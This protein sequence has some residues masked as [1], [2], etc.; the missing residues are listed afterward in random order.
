MKPSDARTHHQRVI[1][2]TSIAAA[3]AIVVVA[4]TSPKAFFYDEVEYLLGTVTLLERLGP[5][6]A[7]LL[8]YAHPA[9][10]LFG[11]MHWVFEPVTRLSPPAVRLVNPAL[12]LLL[13]LVVARLCVHAGVSRPWTSAASLACVPMTWVLAGLALTEMV[14]MLCAALGLWGF[15]AQVA[16]RADPVRRWGVI[17][18]S[19]LATG[20]AFFSRPPLL[21]VA[22]APLLYLSARP[23]PWREVTVFLASA[24]V[25]VT[26]AVLLWGGL[27]PPKVDFYSS[28]TFSVSHAALA[29][30][31]AGVVMHLLCPAWYDWSPV[32]L[33][34]VVAAAVVANALVPVLEITALGT[35]A[36]RVLAD[37]L[38]VVYPRLVGGLCLGVGAV[39]LVTTL[40]KV[41]VNR[42]DVAWLA[43][44]VTMLLIVLA[45]GKITHQFSSRYVGVAAPFM[46]VAA[47]RYRRFD[48]LEMFGAALGAVLGAASLL[49]YYW[50]G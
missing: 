14:G 38:L 45:T 36:N 25:V 26:P 2:A 11:L 41:A 44:A 43:V 21:V 28:S 49:S 7:F 27:V 35:L 6:R 23:R 19:G 39:F 50:G 24:A 47:G 22:F 1:L 13:V 10:S 9:G 46:V 4:T 12:A 40:R 3:L 37:S 34:G 15:V 29:L 5:G 16:S 48:R 31:Y 30:G 42:R 32:S 18:L 17:V 8:E 20:I 33:I